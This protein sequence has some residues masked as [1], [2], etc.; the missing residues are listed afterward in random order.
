VLFAVQGLGSISHGVNVRKGPRY[1][2][3]GKGSGGCDFRM[4]TG[5]ISQHLRITDDIAVVPELAAFK[6]P[7]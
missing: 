6:A 5:N 2:L 4:T 1:L 3:W 7:G